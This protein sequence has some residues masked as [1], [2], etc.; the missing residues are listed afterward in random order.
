MRIKADLHVHSIYSKD[1]LITS[2]DLVFY[3]KKR[4]LNAV[5]V[6]DHDNFEGAFKIAKETDFLIIPGMEVSSRDGH[7]VAL[8]VSEPV[9]RGLSAE[10]TVDLIHKAGGIGIACHAYAFF[11]GSL[12]NNVSAKF[13]AIETV[14]ARAFPFYHSCRKAEQAAKN[15]GISRVGGTDAHYGPQVGY[16]YTTV[17]S[18][19][20]VEAI[21]KAIVAGRCEPFGEPVP[22]FTNFEMTV[23]RFKRMAK[24]AVG[25]SLL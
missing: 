1:S 21:T 2:R 15:L 20:T 3:A 13:D 10:E 8:N 11:K 25:R 6:T 19:P 18:E 4:G 17:D 12:G 23:Q 5:A 7:I 24:K 9:Q 16:G 14:N 22:V